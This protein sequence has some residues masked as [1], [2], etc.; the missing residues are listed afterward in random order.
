MRIL[1]HFFNAKKLFF[2]VAARLGRGFEWRTTFIPV[3]INL[4]WRLIIETISR[5]AE[6]AWPRGIE[7]ARKRIH[8][9]QGDRHG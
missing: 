9:E 8:P 3:L 2:R 7:F 4:L 6:G 5:V 1:K